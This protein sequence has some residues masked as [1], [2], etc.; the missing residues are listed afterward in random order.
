[1]VS[2]AL[3][4]LITCSFTSKLK[5]CAQRMSGKEPPT[6]YRSSR[7][8][9]FNFFEKDWHKCF[10]VNFAKFPRTTFSHHRTPPMAASVD[11]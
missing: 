8:E 7:P 4:E 5:D 10:L 1:M 9:V 6:G 3:F 2:A 11:V